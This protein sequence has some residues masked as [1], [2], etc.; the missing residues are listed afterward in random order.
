MQ[1]GV[2]ACM[3]PGLL[4]ARG[5]RAASPG[6]LGPPA[7]ALMSSHSIWLAGYMRPAA[8]GLLP[9][10]G[11]HLTSV[12]L[13]HDPPLSAPL[14]TDHP[15]LRAPSALLLAR[16]LL[17]AASAVAVEAAGWWWRS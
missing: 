10:W 9:G 12:T 6:P 17:H 1:G 3:Q 7:A 5:S 11:H 4:H 16:L 14:A 15:H 8:G 2:A 13:D